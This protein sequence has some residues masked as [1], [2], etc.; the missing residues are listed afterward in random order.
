MPEYQLEHLA[1]NVVHYRDARIIPLNGKGFEVN[2]AWD[3]CVIVAPPVCTC[4]R[5][6]RLY[7]LQVF[8]T[9]FYSHTCTRHAH[10]HIAPTTSRP[11]STEVGMTL[12]MDSAKIVCKFCVVSL[13]NVFTFGLI[14]DSLVICSIEPRLRSHRTPTSPNNHLRGLLPAPYV[15]SPI[16]VPSPKQ[17]K[18]K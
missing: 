3:M 14:Y 17:S 2:V 10:T 6:T 11:F 8:R 5:T 18:G 9:L 4:Y 1:Q 13:P 7:P 15:I 16:C 12:N